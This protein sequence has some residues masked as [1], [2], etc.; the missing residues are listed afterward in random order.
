[1]KKVITIILSIAMLTILFVGC[2]ATSAKA[3]A[4]A[5]SAKASK[6]STLT[7]GEIVNQLNAAGLPVDEIIVY[8]AETDTNRLL[9][10]P[11]QYISK[12]N[13]A[14]T[15]VA[16]S[17]DASNPVGGSIE[18]FSNAADLKARKDYLEQIIKTIPAFTQYLYV[19]GNYL[20]R[21]DGAVTPDN[22]AKYEKSFAAIK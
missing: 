15:T 8:T 12:T 9:G 17:G 4:S 7:A 14:D 11:N 3:T 13:F 10:R 2:S 6:P 16:Q 20:L 21:I 5:S 19:N 18:T 1:M 22:A